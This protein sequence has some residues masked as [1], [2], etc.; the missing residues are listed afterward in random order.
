[1]SNALDDEALTTNQSEEPTQPTDTQDEGETSSPRE[2]EPPAGAK[3]WE[4]ALQRERERY[5]AVRAAE[6]QKEQELQELKAKL[7]EYELAGL[8]E[9]DRYRAEAQKAREE[10]ETLRMKVE[11]EEIK[12]EYRRILSEKEATNP[13]TVSFLRK[14]MEKDIYPVQGQTLDEFE[15]NFADFATD[16]EGTQPTQQPVANS[17]PAYVPPAEV[18]ITKLSASEMRKFLPI[19]EPKDN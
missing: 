9:V 15:T 13:R 17:N 14:Q 12:K 10:A 11:A 5:K 6:A 8:S 4:S 19:A 18:D 2:P 1:M 7:D 16:F 3:S